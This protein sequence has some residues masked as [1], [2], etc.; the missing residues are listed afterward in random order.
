MDSPMT[1]A[2]QVARVVAVLKAYT[3]INDDHQDLGSA[4]YAGIAAT[5][6]SELFPELDEDDSWL[7]VLDAIEA[8]PPMARDAMP[9]PRVVPV[10]PWYG[11]VRHLQRS[12][13]GYPSHITACGATVGGRA[14]RTLATTLI[15]TETTC[16]RCRETV[17]FWE[18]MAPWARTAP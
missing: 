12:H 17:Y 16:Q 7:D 1:K 11:P 8:V 13:A 15:P 6:V 2:E 10:L 5:I 4:D 18:R 3:V 14:P 9:T